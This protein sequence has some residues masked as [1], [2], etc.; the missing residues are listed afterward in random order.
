MSSFLSI[1]YHHMYYLPFF[2]MNYFMILL[3][4]MTSSRCLVVWPLLPHSTKATTNLIL[5]QES[6]YLLVTIKKSK[7]IFSWIILQRNIHLQECLLL[8]RLFSFSSETFNRLSFLPYDNN[9]H[10][11]NNDLIFPTTYAQ[12]SLNH[13]FSA[14]T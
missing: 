4:H 11:T 8:W 6:S 2:N 10:I 13:P 1:Y 9:L 12:Y 3:L 5:M 14:S 7:T